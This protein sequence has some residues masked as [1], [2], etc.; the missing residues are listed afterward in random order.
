MKSATLKLKGSEWLVQV[1]TIMYGNKTKTEVADKFPFNPFSIK[2]MREAYAF[3]KGRVKLLNDI[4]KL[5]DEKC[6]EFARED[7]NVH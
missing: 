1:D 7:A 4:F 3:A 5:L 6:K 2:D